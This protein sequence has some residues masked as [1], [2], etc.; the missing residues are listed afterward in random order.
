MYADN[1]IRHNKNDNE[2]KKRHSL[3]FFRCVF[4]L[5]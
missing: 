2:A 1:C 3:L 5:D 4:G